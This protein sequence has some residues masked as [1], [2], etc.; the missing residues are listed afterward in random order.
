[1]SQASRTGIR[2][3]SVH[4][5]DQDG[6]KGLYRINAVDEVA[7]GWLKAQIPGPFRL[8]LELEYTPTHEHCVIRYTPTNQL[9]MRRLPRGRKRAYRPPR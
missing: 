4:Q 9:R 3:D 1:M 7:Q 2:I 6:V 8:I 5:G